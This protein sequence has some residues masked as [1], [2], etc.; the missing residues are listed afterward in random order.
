[1]KKN[2]IISCIIGRM[3]NGDGTYKI[4]PLKEGVIP[5]RDRVGFVEGRL[6]NFITARCHDGK[7]SLVLMAKWNQGCSTASW[8]CPTYGEERYRKILDSIINRVYVV[9]IETAEYGCTYPTSVAFVTADRD[10]AQEEFTRCKVDILAWQRGMEAREECEF[11]VEETEDTYF[12]YKKGNSDGFHFS[13]T[14]HEKEMV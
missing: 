3:S 1:M 6:A 10:K 12:C 4:F 11:P 14:V 8:P 2:E 7:E 13:V 9:T 5:E